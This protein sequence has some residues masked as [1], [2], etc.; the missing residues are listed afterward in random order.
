MVILVVVLRGFWPC[1][2]NLVKV[3]F[4]SHI[5]RT[6]T[7]CSKA[8]HLNYSPIAQPSGFSHSSLSV[9][10]REGL[11]RGQEFVKSGTGYSLEHATRPST[12]GLILS[13]S[14][15]ALL[16]WIGEKFLAWSDV[17]PDLDTILEGVMLYWVTESGGRGVYPYRQ[18]CSIPLLLSQY[19]FFTDIL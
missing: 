19:F 13:S 3:C 9:R 4:P 1:G 10:E 14:P 8:V 16:A 5:L 2:L 12:I 7:D 18:V 11:L 15:L 6:L 17:S